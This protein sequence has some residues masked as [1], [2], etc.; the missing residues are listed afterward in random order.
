M[1]NML[2][3]YKNWRYSDTFRETFWFIRCKIWDFAYA[4]RSVLFSNYEHQLFFKTILLWLAAVRTGIYTV[5][6]AGGVLSP[7]SHFSFYPGYKWTWVVSPIP[8]QWM[9]HS[10]SIT[11]VSSSS[12]LL[13]SS[14][15]CVNDVFPRDI[16]LI[17]DSFS[18]SCLTNSPVIGF[19]KRKWHACSQS[20]KSKS[21]LYSS[22]EG[23]NKRD[24]SWPFV[25]HLPNL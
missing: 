25:K 16:W 12:C 5:L 10:Q 11:L 15:C 14:I 7:I 9:G 23:K 22:T 1:G 17:S 20:Q 2:G 18:S 13:S 6:L 24:Y 21:N 8:F 3:N 4:I 19:K